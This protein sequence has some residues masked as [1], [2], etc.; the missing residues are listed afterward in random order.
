MAVLWNKIKRWWHRLCSP[1]HFYHFAGKHLAWTSASAVLC[2]VIGLVW[3]L[4]FAPADYLQGNSF[5]IIY[6][7]VPAAILS[8][9]VYVSMAICCMVGLIWKIK[10]SFMVARSLAVIGAA[11]T[12]IALFTGSIWGKPTWGTWWVW[13][14]RLTSEL[15][16][17]FLYLGFLGLNQALPDRS[18]ANKSSAILAIVGVTNIPIIHYS[19]VWWQSLHQ[20]STI[21]K[22][23]KPSIAPEMLWPLLIM[24]LAFSLIVV[25]FVFLN[26]RTQILNQRLRKV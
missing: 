22:F 15:I 26:T 25:S 24:L 16:L 2:Y 4:G 11:F 12:V 7:H 21:L 18:I 19:V 6:L 14:A 8:M 5:R 9:G 10:L 3:G 13:D 17:L 1:G 20:G 23:S